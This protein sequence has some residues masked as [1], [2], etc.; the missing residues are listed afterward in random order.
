M[1][2]DTPHA[3]T[4]HK[5]A[6]HALPLPAALAFYDQIT[7]TGDEETLRWMCRN[8]RYFLLV[9]IIGRTDMVNDWCYSR[10][11]EVEASSDG[12]L[13]LWSRG[14]YKSTIITF[15]GTI[16]EILRDPNITIC[17]LS[18][19]GSTAQAF[20]QQIKIGLEMPVLINLFP[21]IL[22]AKPPNEQWSVKNGLWVKRTTTVKEAT[23]FA[24]GLVD[25]QPTSKHFALRIYDD[26]VTPESVSTPDQIKKTTAAW[27]L[28]DN[29]GIGDGSRVWM[30]GT[31]YHPL[32]TYN[33]ILKR[34]SV[35]ERRRICEDENGNPLLLSRETL[36]QKRIDMGIRIYAAQMLQNPVGEGVRMFKT[37]WLQYYDRVPDRA[38][39]NVYIIIDSANAKRKQNDYTTIW[40]IGLGADGNYYVLDIVRDRLNLS[41]RTAALFA[42]HRKWRPIHVYWEQVGA[43]SDTAHVRE[44]MDRDNYRFLIRDIGQR[45][46][47]HDR[48]AWLIPLFESA[49]IWFPRRLLYTATTGETRDLVLDFIDYEFDVYPVV[50]HDDMLDSLANI[51]HPECQDMY[52][53]K[54][55][56]EV[57]HTTT[58]TKITYTKKG[59][60]R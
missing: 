48:I 28:S 41:E 33:D 5:E 21:D 59:F 10:C 23:V 58:P 36:K 56:D 7:K 52:F 9:A 3:L 8:D 22:W 55:P 13:D 39:L 40:V 49:K 4:L 45:V 6:I 50:S 26:V 17:I 57:T 16:Q 42:L 15:A 38:R 1:V 30:V 32:D 20:V 24:G 53:P 2:T 31:R 34:K 54:N 44:I 14:H 35:R 60:L 11:R 29:L 12:W 47:K 37:D 51:K 18:Y 43:M 27:E 25:A 19:N 46:S